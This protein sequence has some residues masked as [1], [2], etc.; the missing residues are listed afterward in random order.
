VIMD[1]LKFN[2]SRL[3]Y[4]MDISCLRSNIREKLINQ[5]QPFLN[6]NGN[7]PKEI[8]DIVPVSSWGRRRTDPLIEKL[9]RNSLNKALLKFPFSDNP[10]KEIKLAIESIA[11]V[12]GNRIFE[13]ILKKMKDPDDIIILPVKRGCLVRDPNSSKSYLFLKTRLFRNTSYSS[14]C[15]TIYFTSALA[16]PSVDCVMLHGVGIK[17]REK[18]YIFLGLSSSGK[19]TIANLSSGKNIISDDGLIVEKDNSCFSISMAPLN[20]SSDHIEEEEGNC[21]RRSVLSAGFLL[22]KD[23]KNYLE[24]LLPENVC[25]T[26]IKNHIHYFRYFSRKGVE[27]TFYLISGLCRRIPFY[28]L[29]FKKDAS[30]WRSIEDEMSRI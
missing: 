4:Q 6:D 23:N 7:E 11:P 26:I 13:L 19:S 1:Y 29:H 10:D 28:A 12:S 24:K 15:D 20:Q 21:Y 3:S 17:D 25:S 30:F 2:I 27:K 18:G 22:V 5:F 8:I 9:I 14:I 16:L